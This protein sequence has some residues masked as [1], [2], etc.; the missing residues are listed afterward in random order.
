MVREPPLAN[1]RPTELELI[2]APDHDWF[3]L[4]RPPKNPMVRL[5]ALP[6]HPRTSK[7][8]HARLLSVHAVVSVVPGSGEI[9]IP[10]LRRK[11]KGDF[12]LFMDALVTEL[13]DHPVR[14]TNVFMSDDEAAKA[15]DELDRYLDEVAPGM[16]DV[17]EVDDK[18][19]LEDVLDGFTH[20]VED[21]GRDTADTLVGTWDTSRER[22]SDHD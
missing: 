9:R 1:E 22:N 12:A 17:N 5:Q 19:R 11:D 6:V 18:K 14:F 20:E 10:Y 2:Q 4:D 7:C 21:W 3:P 15:Y 16:N 13:G 8:V